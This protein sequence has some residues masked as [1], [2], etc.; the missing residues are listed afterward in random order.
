MP[1]HDTLGRV[2][3]VLDSVKFEACFVR[4]MSML[5]PSL[6]REIVTIDGKTARS[7]RERAM[8]QTAAD[9]T[10]DKRYFVSSLPS[11]SQ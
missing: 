9:V 1:S 5:C 4:W 8:R 3:A 11:H 2:F 10:A 6:E 7:S